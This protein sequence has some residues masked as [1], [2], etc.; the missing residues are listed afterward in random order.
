MM[1]FP[2]FVF[3]PIPDEKREEEAPA[4]RKLA[5]ASERLTPKRSFEP[6]PR[7]FDALESEK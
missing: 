3:V 1:F 7:S 6:L 5:S 2:F 4:R